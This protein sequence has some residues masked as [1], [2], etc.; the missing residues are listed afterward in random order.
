M[1]DKTEAEHLAHL[2][3]VLRRLKEQRLYARLKKCKFFQKECKFL[4]FVI[5]QDGCVKPDPQ[6]TAALAEWPVPRNP[7]DV[8]SFLGLANYLRRF[9]HRYAAMA[10]PLTD[11]T[12]KD[13][14]FV[15]GAV[16]QEAFD[17]LKH[18]LCNA[19]VVIAPD[20][21]KP[22]V[23][24]TDASAKH[25]SVGGC[26]L[27][28]AGSGLQPVAYYSRKLTNAE[29]KLGSIY[30]LE[31]LALFECL[32]QWR[33]YVDG[34]G[35]TAYTDHDSLKYLKS[36]AE[37][38][39]R[40]AKWLQ[41]MAEVDVSIKHHPGKENV[42]ADALSRPPLHCNATVAQIAPG[43]ALL[44]EMRAAYLMDPA[45]L[46]IIQS[47]HAGENTAFALR[48][49][50]L[51]WDCAEGS[52]VFVPDHAD[53]R[54]RLLYEYHD[55]MLAGHLG[56]AKTLAA[57]SAEWY[58]PGM[59]ATVH[60]YVTTCTKCQQN[61]AVNQR[62]IGLLQPLPI[63]D[64]PWGVVTMDFITQLPPSLGFDSIF[65]MICKLT[66]EVIF[67]ATHTDIT[68]VDAAQ[69][70]TD[71]V[72][73]GKGT[74]P[75]A[76]VSDRDPKF[77]SHFWSQV[78]KLLDTKLNMSSSYHPETDGQTERQNRVLEEMLR[79]YCQVKHSNWATGLKR[80]QFAVN[81]AVHA[82][83]GFTPFHLNGVE[84]RS[85]IQMLC[86]TV[87]GC[88]VPAAAE[89]MSALKS[90]LEL[91]KQRLKVA[92]DRQSR[93]A[94]QR[95]REV[96]F[97]AGDRI[98]LS[99]ADLNL[100][101]AGPSRKLKPKYI[102]PFTIVEMVSP[103][104]CK[105]KLP[106]NYRIHPVVHVSR[107]QPFRETDNFPSRAN[108][109]APPPVYYDAGE[110]FWEVEAV[111]NRRVVSVTKYVRR[112]GR[113]RRTVVQIPEYEVKWKG[114]PDSENMWRRTA[115]ISDAAMELV[116]EYDAAHPM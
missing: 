52:K 5:G 70:F 113:R 8:R 85:P 42:I 29:M 84:T 33:H 38:S 39:P 16:H 60:E 108:T 93:Y 83:T 81:N 17:S 95:R 107:V 25:R 24:H 111:V 21:T 74:V 98:L 10:A 90:D 18:A 15:W 76:V 57:V 88:T 99:T 6:K 54:G 78:F 12:K 72:V 80:C 67:E 103:V 34:P 110:P 7:T 11:L 106:A 100:A 77:T 36:Q 44:D 73:C 102:G 79:S 41:L 31:A 66:K 35:V 14:P 105:L 50:L 89:F 116:R 59:K 62:P 55:S 26:L 91:A 68:A 49:G 45:A 112:R 56:V 48:D 86:R 69:I 64:R 9:V 109:S 4:G 71:A 58:W 3:E 97:Q 28:D 115:D 53:L 37:L 51:L 13:Q 47:I 82:S 92:Q 104:A 23:I 27:Q 96:Q 30:E 61:K 20:T 22:F 87:P 63:P 65:V 75:D 40:Q 2:E 19:P 43:A 32:H 94:N 101:G 46:N 114:Y 1:F